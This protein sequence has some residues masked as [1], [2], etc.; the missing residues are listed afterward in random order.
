MIGRTDLALEAAADYQNIPGIEQQVA[1]REGATVTR[2]T[3]STAEAARALGK[4]AGRYITVEVPPLSDN[5]ER[6]VTHARVIGE[7]LAAL[8]PATGPVLVV[9]LGNAAITPDALGP[10][11]ADMVLATRHIQGEWAR[12]MGL[13]DLRPV[14]V[15]PA[16]VLGK[17]GVESGELTRGV[18]RTVEP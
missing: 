4:P 2:T 5:E 15:V 1:A 12:S 3:I 9:A 13:S 10:W 7:E 18:C 6:L 8:L 14:A 16:G 17:T 11:A